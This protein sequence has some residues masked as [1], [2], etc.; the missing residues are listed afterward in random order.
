MESF[1]KNPTRDSSPAFA[2]IINEAYGAMDGTDGGGITH[3]VDTDVTRFSWRN[4]WR[5]STPDDQPDVEC[6]PIQAETC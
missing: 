2:E 4:T 3:G 6:N 5:L 1:I